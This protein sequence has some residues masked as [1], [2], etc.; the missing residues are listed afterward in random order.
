MIKQ[1]NGK[2]NVHRFL[3]LF[4]FLVLDKEIIWIYST[5]FIEKP[6]FIAFNIKCIHSGADPTDYVSP[7]PPS[8][9]TKAP[10]TTSCKQ[11]NPTIF[12]IQPKRINKTQKSFFLNFVH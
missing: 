5:S 1:I 4:V 6:A 12:H 7:A 11:S 8:L 9:T 2:L 3:E 10:Q